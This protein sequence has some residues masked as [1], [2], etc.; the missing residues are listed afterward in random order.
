[1]KQLVVSV[2]FFAVVL[3][4]AACGGGA[5]TPVPTMAPA[6]TSAP[7]AAAAPSDATPAAPAAPKVTPVVPLDDPNMQKT[8]SGLKYSDI[9]AGTGATPAS[10]DWVTVQ[11]TVTLQDGTLIADSSTRGGPENIPLD[12]LAKGIPGWAEGMSTMKVG[13]V[14]E[15][16]VPPNLAFGDKG[17]G[18]VIPPNATLVFV[19]ELLDTKPAPQV[20]ID[21]KVVGTG[22]EAKAGMTVKIDYTGTLTN[23][24]VFGSS[25]GKQPAEFA[26]GAQQG[27]PGWDQGL[28]GMK[29]GGKRT[30]TVPPE[31]AYGA[32]G[33]G[34]TIPPNATLIF[35]IEL[36]DVQPP[37]QVKI[38]DIQVGTGAEAV[39]GKT[40]KVNYTG[41]LEN[42]TVFDS[43]VGKQPFEFVLGAGQVIPGWDQGLQGMKVGGK[44]TL[45]IPPSL[46]YGAQGAGSTIPPNSTLIFE[47]ELLDVK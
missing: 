47:V 38:E 13:G 39:P 27:G 43:S 11:Y 37:A 24:T 22:A 6:P 33:D 10:A 46:G 36:L 40:L 30:L 2:L 1:M 32:R 17:S 31:L 18:S 45:T 44:R 8:T 20:K 42:G 7:T 3:G 15:L 21:D 4:L 14:R 23:G 9:V 16:V 5:A 25:A 19:V 29:V 35:E 26:L 34:G 28:Q 12:D 41:K